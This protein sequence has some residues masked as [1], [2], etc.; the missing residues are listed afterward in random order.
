MLEILKLLRDSYSAVGVK[1]EFE[2]EG[3]RLDEM[4]RFAD[5]A[6]KSDLKL[7]IKI[8]GCEAIKDAFDAKQFGADYVIA[9]MIESSYA[10]SKFS[11]LVDRV[12]SSSF[13]RPVALFNI[14][15]Q[16]AYDNFD[17]I[18][19]YALSSTY[20]DGMYWSC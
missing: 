2:S 4:L 13:K 11:D 17:S 3:V 16:L 14:E 7:G 5:I 18:L 15:T 10:L 12:Y 20:I 1:A 8:G 9:P 6:H 19:A